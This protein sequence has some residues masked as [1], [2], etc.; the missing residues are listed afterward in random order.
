[1][2]FALLRRWRAAPPPPQHPLAPPD[3]THLLRE[4]GRHPDVRQALTLSALLSLI[5]TLLT[6]T[7][8]ITAAQA[9]ATALLD[10]RLPATAVT[11][12]IAVSL[13]G[14]AVTAPLRERI[15]TRMAA[16]RL[17]DLRA[18]LTHAALTLGP[19]QLSA[20]RSSH[21]N[22]LD[23]DLDTRLAPYF[24]RF[25]PARWHAAITT[26]TL[27]IVTALLDPATA[28]LLA[29]TGPL[30]IL[31]LWLVGLA[32]HAAT[33]RQWQ[34]HTR[35]NARL[36]TVTAHLPLLHLHGQVSTYRRVLKASA[37]QHRTLTLNVLKIA[38][39]SGLVLEFAVTLATAL[40]AV[41]IGVRLFGGA[42][43]LAPTLAALML[44]AEYFG[45]L[46]QLGADRHAAMDAE[47]LATHLA[48]LRRMTPVLTG[49]RPTE[50]GPPTLTFRDARAHFPGSGGAGCS[51]LTATVPAG[52]HVT[53]RGPSGSGKTSL[54]HA[55][56][57]HVPFQGDILVNGTPL[58]HL[59]ADAW[60]AHVAFIPQH[61]HL[62]AASLRVNL[63]VTRPDASDTNLI[64]VATQVGL[65]DLIRHLPQGL[66]TPLGEGG[67]HLSGGE[68]ARLSLARALLTTPALVLLDEPTAHLD[69]ETEA[70][71][72]QV[73][74]AAFRSS[75]VVL[76]THHAI[77][78]SAQHLTLAGRAA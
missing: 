66:D 43:S 56:R 46:R 22:L 50:P 12:T 1:M 21:L 55:L 3:A 27:L 64:D 77:N 51:P 23:T 73:I 38:F 5:S 54:L 41:W 19:V 15:L 2:T 78:F 10:H 14:R 9:I 34:A 28:L 76:V 75:T 24:A 60:R 35:L 7:F 48:A 29:I 59:D 71:I 25:L 31:F 42:A 57:R 40:V 53:L 20:Q 67:L 52:T 61:P 32:A 30:T 74:Q 13:L 18:D 11:L 62:L 72:V 47:P 39:L 4:L 45:P 58:Q 65:L 17:H 16:R 36:L 6:A 49:Q 70:A 68:L 37:E 8:A 44:V 33:D 69:P 63:S 26:P